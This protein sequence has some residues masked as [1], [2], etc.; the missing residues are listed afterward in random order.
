MEMR[1]Y[2]MILC[3]LYKD[4]VTNEE[5]SAKIEQAIGPHRELLTIVKRCK[6]KW[7]GYI[8]CSSSLAKAT[9]QG[10]VK[11]GRRQ[12]GQEKKW[13][14]NIKEWTGTEFAKSQRTVENRK[15]MEKTGCKIICG[16]P[17]TLTVKGLMM[18]MITFTYSLTMG[19]DG[20]PEMTSQPASSIFL[21]SP[22]LS[23]T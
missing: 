21:C 5:V 13:E 18:M 15:K 14:D 3:I 4:H 23:G 6:L 12:G 9:R 8:S 20:A 16:A 17:I 7:Y 10:T 2:G 1:S 22:P 11:G 19:V